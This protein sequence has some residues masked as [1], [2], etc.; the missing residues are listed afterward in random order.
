MRKY[1]L[2]KSEVKKKLKIL[3][4]I[5]L[6]KAVIFLVGQATGKKMKLDL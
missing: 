5:K 1:E 2:M 3:F 6:V 4:Y